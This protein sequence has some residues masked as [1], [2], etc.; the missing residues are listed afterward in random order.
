M[1]LRDLFPLGRFS[2]PATEAT[3]VSVEEQL[4]TRL[5][6]QLRRL[7]FECDGFRED[8][9]N[10]KYLLSLRDEDF[11]G[12]LLSTTKFMWSEFERPDLKSFVF[13]GFSSGDEAWGISTRVPGQIIAYHHHMED[14]YQ[15]VGSDI[16]AVFEA[17][18]RRYEV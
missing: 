8:K 14:E 6:E 2:S 5:P 17:E 4:G 13:F 9:G 7:Y 11:I 15:A 1:S 10:A 12:S 16:I 18:Y 3:I